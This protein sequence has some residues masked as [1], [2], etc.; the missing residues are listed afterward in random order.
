ML[1]YEPEI[2]AI[3]YFI[4]SSNKKNYNDTTID[5][6]I[7]VDAS[8]ICN[9][10]NNKGFTLIKKNE[11]NNILSNLIKNFPSTSTSEQLTNNKRISEH[12]GNIEIELNSFLLEKEKSEERT[13]QV[14]EKNK[15]TVKSF[16]T[17]YKL[18]S[19]FLNFRTNKVSIDLENQKEWK[20]SIKEFLSKLFLDNK[21]LFDSFKESVEKNSTT[22]KVLSFCVEVENE[23]S[24]KVSDEISPY[25]LDINFTNDNLKKD[26]FTGLY[27]FVNYSSSNPDFLINKEILEISK[28]QEKYIVRLKSSNYEGDEIGRIYTGEMIIGEGSLYFSLI[29]QN[30]NEKSF[31]VCNGENITDNFDT[32]IGINTFY[33]TSQKVS[34][35][36]KIVLFKIDDNN[37]LN[38][39]EMKASKIKLSEFE[40]LF[41]DFHIKGLTKYSLTTEKK[42]IIKS[43]ILCLLENTTGNIS[44]VNKYLAYNNILSQILYSH[45]SL[46]VLNREQKNKDSIII[47]NYDEII[48]YLSSIG[49]NSNQIGKQIKEMIQ[50]NKL[51]KIAFNGFY[52]E[53][54]IY[55]NNDK[56]YLEN[57]KSIN[58]VLDQIFIISVKKNKFNTNLPQGTINLMYT[59]ENKDCWLFPGRHVHNLSYSFDELKKDNISYFKKSLSESDFELLNRDYDIEIELDINKYL[60][61]YKQ[62]PIYDHKNLFCFIFYTI[63]FYKKDSTDDELLMMGNIEFNGS[64]G[65]KYRWINYKELL[66]DRNTIT[67]KK[68]SDVLQG[69]ERLYGH[70]FNSSF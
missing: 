15:S 1:L 29:S 7:Y 49:L 44:F 4:E 64:E 12:I 35:S 28:S 62:D 58:L 13:I 22:Q 31:V 69:I 54:P 10:V 65:L 39:N 70:E 25:T 55:S 56:N 33:S 48:K 9:L 21:I 5:S 20:K 27:Y 2:K 59:K 3:I 67:Y 37:S 16:T 40:K 14:D 68:N 36:K 51:D 50:N 17:K 32:I 19:E 46:E 42:D 57:Q 6:L 34:T 26:K 45:D 60:L 66:E 30:G 47:E 11:N 61:T 43:N 53:N 38:F 41:D 23:L 63:K 24:K 8:N 52:Y 18:K